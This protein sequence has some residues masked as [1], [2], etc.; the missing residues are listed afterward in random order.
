MI[1]DN[2]MS[3]EEFK[4]PLSDKD[5]WEL[6]NSLSLEPQQI[7]QMDTSQG[8]IQLKIESLSGKE[9]YATPRLATSLNLSGLHK[10]QWV[11]DHSRYECEAPLTLNEKGFYSIQFLNP[12]YKLQRRQNFRSQL[13]QNWK[14]EIIVNQINENTYSLNGQVQDLSLTGCF[15]TTKTTGVLKEKDEISGELYIG[16]FKTVYFK[17]EILRQLKSS[18]QNSFGIRFTHL[19][20]FGK[21]TLNQITLKAARE[22]RNYSQE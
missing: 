4:N 7:I 13:P 19:E 17:G 3:N 8:K 15:F 21:E 18:D 5:K 12:I 16:E 1:Y 2:S 14:R 20:N 11:Y 10:L 9:I 22:S 6:I